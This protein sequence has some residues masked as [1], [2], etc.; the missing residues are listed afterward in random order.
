MNPNQLVPKEQSLK[1]LVSGA[2]N[3]LQR[4]DYSRRSL[5]RYQIVWEKLITFANKHEFGNRLSEKLIAQFL[6]HHGITDA[7]ASEEEGWRRHAAF[8]IKTLWNFS[9]YGYFERTITQM[10]KLNIPL[11]MKKTLNEYEKYCIEKRYLSHPYVNSCV[12]EISIFLDFIGKKNIKKLNQI[13]AV[14]LSEFVNSLWRFSTPTISTI[15]SDVR[16]FLRFLLLRGILTEDISQALPTIRIAQNA[17]IPSVWDHELIIK[18]L[19]AVDRGSARG[20]RDYAMLLL[21]CRL[22]LRISDILNLTLDQIN[23]E[24]ATIS[25]TQSKT[26]AP[27]SLPLTNEVGNALID[28]ISLSRPKTTHREV[29]LKLAPPF[30]PFGKSNNCHYIVNYW[31]QLAGIK[32][33]SR[34]RHGMHSLRHSLATRLLEKQTP[35]SVISD[36]LGHT[37]TASTMIYAK[38]NIEALRHVSL[39][40]EEVNNAK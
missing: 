19:A 15:I 26:K 13:K 27:L 1:K 9:R 39:S 8:S 18:L 40:P 3:Q 30:P 25:I 12:R 35:F 24:S 14:N 2:L 28:Y 20:K 10:H 22:G 21:A 31:R 38:A 37:S 23:W 34:Q 29:F 17:K 7:S 36:I 5:S 32:F 4:I 16:L 6:K 33:R 11:A